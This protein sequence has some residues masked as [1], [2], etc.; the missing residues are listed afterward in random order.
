MRWPQP[1]DVAVLWKREFRIDLRPLARRAR[2]RPE[3]VIVGL[4]V[5]LRVVTYLWN[6][7]MWL[8]ESSLRGNVVDVPIL[9]FSA[10][11]WQ[12]QL[13]PL[14]FLVVERILATFIGSRNYVLRSLPLAAGIAALFLFERLTRR[15]LPRRPALVAL[16][17]FAVSDDLIYYASE[18]KP[19]SLDLVIGLALT[20]LSGS[21][22]GSRPSPRLI[23]W[24]GL[25]LAA[26]PWFSFASVFVVAGCGM[27]LV[28]DGLVGRR[29]RIATLWL[30]MGLGWLAN[31]ALSYHASH[32]LLSPYTTMYRFWD[33]AFLPVGFPPTR[34]GL[35]RSV[36]LLLEV[37]VNPLN[38]LT[39]P[40]STFGVVLPLFL[41]AAG[42][43]GLAR[44]L[45]RTFLLLAAPIAL[46]LGAAVTRHY[47]FHGRLLLELVP[48]M[49]LVIAEGTE[50]VAR[51]FPGRGG[52]AYGTLLLVLLAYPCWDACYQ[53]TGRR[54]RYF[55][56]HGDLHDNVFIDREIR[57]A[58]RGS[59]EGR[60]GV[61]R[62]RVVPGGD[63]ADHVRSPLR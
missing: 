15:V 11:L 50:W 63:A 29:F 34:D 8:D 46:A 42:C 38:L 54:T 1:S 51:R 57:P 55:N 37:F 56:L 20:L 33:F 14:G 26:A 45:P 61:T 32:A 23:L 36:G 48:A 22:L 7:A 47:P 3:A 52:F 6:R 43:M 16:V 2:E 17:L 27:V 60:R 28:G 30:T 10:P 44:R 62:D 21:A 41:L 35:V 31:F 9:D 19:Y 18:F 58:G 49:F 24:I 59:A 4:G 40:D 13:A 25:L 53:C 39:P 5:A 12:D